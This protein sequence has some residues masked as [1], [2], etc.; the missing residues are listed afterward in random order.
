MRS[1]ASSTHT[2][3]PC[4]TALELYHVDGQISNDLLSV[5]LWKRLHQYAALHFSGRCDKISRDEHVSLHPIAGPY[6]AGEGGIVGWFVC[7]SR[8]FFFKTTTKEL[9]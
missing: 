6:V 3:L 4:T 5:T 2:A 1:P 7:F 8:V 9:V